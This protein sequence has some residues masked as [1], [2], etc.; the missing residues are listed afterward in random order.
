MAKK[1]KE[2]YTTDFTM[3]GI[4]VTVWANNTRE[5]KKLTRAKLGKMDLR[6]YINPHATYTD[7]KY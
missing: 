1:K 2:Q 5:A 3:Y 4:P 6:K 7:K